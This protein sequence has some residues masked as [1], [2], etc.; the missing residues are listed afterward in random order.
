MYELYGHVNIA[1]DAFLY[2]K[3]YKNYLYK[4]ICGCHT[5]NI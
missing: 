1:N 2:L 4:I 5:N 3:I